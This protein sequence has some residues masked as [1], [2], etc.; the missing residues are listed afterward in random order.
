M[1]HCFLLFS[2]ATLPLLS[3]SSPYG[4]EEVVQNIIITMCFYDLHISSNVQPSIFMRNHEKKKKK[5]K[6]N[7]R[8]LLVELKNLKWVYRLDIS[9]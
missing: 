5:K 2:I 9:P 6:K 3:T 8:E 4:K 7:D 1:M